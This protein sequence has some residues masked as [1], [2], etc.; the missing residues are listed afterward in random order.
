MKDLAYK[1]LFNYLLEISEGK[2]Y[3]TPEQLSNVIN[4][5]AKQQSVLRKQNK[6][7]IPYKTI[8]RLIHYPIPSIIN[9]LLDGEVKETQEEKQHEIMIVEHKQK[10]IK[11]Q[12]N[13]NKDL[14]HIFMTR[15]FVSNLQQEI[16]QLT[17]LHALLSKIVDTE[18]RYNKLQDEVCSKNATLKN[19]LKV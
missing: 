10:K 11:K 13:N 2:I 9:Y 19:I 5:S 6:F 12:L 4:I 7:P 1:K 17:E 16:E 8:G 3:L 18:D 15:S 14:S